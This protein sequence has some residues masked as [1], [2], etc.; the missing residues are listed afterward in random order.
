M[1]VVHPELYVIISICD[2]SIID[3]FSAQFREVLVEEERYTNPRNAYRKLFSF[4]LSGQS[5]KF[6]ND[7]L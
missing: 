2:E 1:A 3:I 7:L 4:F 6:L 5:R